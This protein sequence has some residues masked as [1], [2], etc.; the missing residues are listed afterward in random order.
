M[1]NRT[2]DLLVDLFKSEPQKSDL[3]KYLEQQD[4]HTVADVEYYTRRFDTVCRG[5]ALC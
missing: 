4:L 1:I 5:K 2:I 3:E